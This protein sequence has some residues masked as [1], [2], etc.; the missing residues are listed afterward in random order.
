MSGEETDGQRILEKL[1]QAVENW[2]VRGRVEG[3][4]RW[5]DRELDSEGAPIRLRI[6]ELLECL[7]SLGEGR[8]RAGKWPEGCDVTHRRADPGRLEVFSAG[9][10]SF[11]E[12]GGTWH[13]THPGSGIRRIGRVGIEARG[14]GRSWIGGSAREGRNRR[15]PLFPPGH[16][17]IAS[18]RSSGRIGGRP[19]ISWRSTIETSEALA[20][21]SSSVGVAPG[22]GRTGALQRLANRVAAEASDLDHPID[23]RPRGMVLWSPAVPSHPFRDA[24]ARPSA[25][26]A[27]GA[28]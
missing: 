25:G 4:S 13:P 2:V 10:R 19:A 15:H 18:W 14:S 6:S 24:H 28:G 26:L 9:W 1:S 7:E 8:R 27:V 5:M 12:S 17:R 11:H 3:L 22:S 23:G 21:S 16:P 20:A